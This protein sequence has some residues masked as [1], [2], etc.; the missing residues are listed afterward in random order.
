[1]N[2]SVSESIIIGLLQGIPLVILVGIYYSVRS[3]SRRR[4]QKEYIHH[5]NFKTH[6]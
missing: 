5:L 4:Y 6:H 3:Y 2:L 1:M